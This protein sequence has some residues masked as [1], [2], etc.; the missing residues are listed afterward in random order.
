MQHTNENAQISNNPTN[1]C[2]N[3]P[4]KKCQVIFFYLDFFKIFTVALLWV[5]KTLTAQVLGYNHNTVGIWITNNFGI[6]IVQTC[7]VVEWSFIKVMAWIT[8]L[9]VVISVIGC[10][11]DGLNS[12]FSLVTTPW[13]ERQTKIWPFKPWHE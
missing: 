7:L 12:C 5:L 3:S 1:S 10:M 8:N 11:T 6:Q 2:T 4:F 9:K 13:L